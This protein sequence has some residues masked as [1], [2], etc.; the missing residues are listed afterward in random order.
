MFATCFSSALFTR[1]KKA[2]LEA[3]TAKN[4][5]TAPTM[6]TRGQPKQEQ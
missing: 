3:F 5:M 4:A 6:D 2:F 1:L